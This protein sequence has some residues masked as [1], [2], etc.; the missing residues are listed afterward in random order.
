MDWKMVELKTYGDEPFTVMLPSIPHK[1]DRVE[2]LDQAYEVTR[3]T[4][5]H[6]APVRLS[7]TKARSA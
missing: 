7:V 5:R 2:Y 4:F 6:N 1:G 3:R